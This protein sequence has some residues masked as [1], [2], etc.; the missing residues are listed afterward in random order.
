MNI[1]KT[2]VHAV[3]VL[4][5]T[6]ALA[7][8]PL[9]GAVALKGPTKPVKPAGSTVIVKVLFTGEEGAS[10]TVSA[11][12]TSDPDGIITNLQGNG[13]TVTL[14]NGKGT[15][16]VTFTIVKNPSSLTRTATLEING[17]TFTVN[18]T[19][20][21][22]KVTI[23]PPKSSFEFFGGPG[24]FD[25]AAPNGCEWGANESSPW[26][27]LDNAA[28]NGNGHV[29]F[30]VAENK[31]KNRSDKILVTAID[32]ISKNPLATKVHTTAQKEQKLTGTVKIGP[33]TPL[34]TTDKAAKAYRTT[35]QAIET[36]ALLNEL[37]GVFG[38]VGLFAETV[39]KEPAGVNPLKP[40]KTAL[41]PLQPVLWQTRKVLESSTDISADICNS[42]TALVEGLIFDPVSG[43]LAGVESKVSIT[44]TDCDL[45]GGTANG[46]ITA[47]GVTI[48]QKT[49]KIAGIITVGKSP[50]EPLR[51]T[52][53]D[54]NLTS[55]LVLKLAF[56]ALDDPA[57]AAIQANGFI[58]ADLTSLRFLVELKGIKVAASIADSGPHSFAMSG[59]VRETT[60]LDGI[61]SVSNELK[62]NDFVETVTP[63]ADPASDLRA[64]TVN[65]MFGRR[66][67]PADSCND[68]NFD[69]ATGKEIKMLYGSPMDGTLLINGATIAINNDDSITVTAGGQTAGYSWEQLAGICGVG[70]MKTGLEFPWN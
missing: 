6:M 47:K 4:A 12:V 40:M 36:V 69:I 22:C 33:L 31:G 5:A 45:G 44:F 35:S 70:A 65:G 66:T 16:K 2:L 25:V 9:W 51:I 54:L 59:L 46:L 43:E 67:T 29:T 8:T 7:A 10:T 19:G 52:G 49:G 63:D 11:T 58:D 13:T 55:F 53:P 48:N 57:T 17:A 34:D 62:M 30:T 56:M 38:P 42:G 68:G 39:R 64:V 23:G 61:F 60:F 3:T 18:Q 50:E 14:N 27:T 41:Q 15:G 32:P 37:I 26:I 21:P 20:L 1:R 28:G 24:A